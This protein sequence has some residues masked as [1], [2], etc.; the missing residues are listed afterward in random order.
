MVYVKI[1]NAR[2]NSN[3]TKNQ[4][5]EEQ[6]CGCATS[7]KSLSIIIFIYLQTVLLNN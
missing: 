6:L 1:V 4:V 5:D 3:S 2:E 7:N